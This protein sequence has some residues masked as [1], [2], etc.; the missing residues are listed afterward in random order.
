MT[1]KSWQFLGGPGS[2][3]YRLYDA[4]R[5]SLNRRLATY[6]ASKVFHHDGGRALEAGSGPAV[7]STLLGRRPGVYAVALDIDAD[8][9]REARKRDPTLPTVIGDVHALPFRS[10][11]FDL[12]WSS[13]TLEHVETPGRALAEMRRVTAPGRFVF[14][15]VPYRWGPLGF[16]PWI[17]RTAFGVWVGPVFSR[18]ELMGEARRAALEPVGV[19]TYFFRFFIG[20]LSRKS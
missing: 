13:S 3:S 11:V 15:G 5:T 1:T 19:I 17:R 2:I 4:V 9:L 20:V 7:A 14:V 8:V 18:A 6:L 16:Q 12:V 10:D